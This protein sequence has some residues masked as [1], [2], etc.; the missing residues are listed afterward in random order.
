MLI[1]YTDLADALAR[2]GFPQ[3]AAEYH[4]TL[5]GALCVQAAEEIEPTQLFPVDEGRALRRDAH[6]EAA[7]A[8]LRDEALASMEN[9]ESGVALLLPDDEE[10]LADRARALALW[11]EG[12]LY[13]LASRDRLDLRRASEEVREIVSDLT[14]FTRADVG[15]GEGGEIEENAY[16]ELVEYVRVGV[17]LI[18]MELHAPASGSEETF[19]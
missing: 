15:G 2:I 8:Q 11:C 6:A 12:F 14:E 5:C 17:Q 4:G 18:F 9:V 13:G 3:D 1:Q 10:T 19:H 16:A 7:L